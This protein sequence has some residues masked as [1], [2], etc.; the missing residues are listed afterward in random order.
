MFAHPRI[1]EI[2]TRVWLKQL[3]IRLNRQINLDNIPP[4]EWLK[5]RN[6]GCDWV[7]LMGVWQ[8]SLIS[9]Q[10]A[11]Q[12]SNLQIEYN[13]VLPDW[14]IEDIVGSPYAVKDYS[15]NYE[16]G[17]EDSL[18]YTKDILHHYGIKL[19]LDF[20]PNHT[21][22]DHHWVFEHPEYYIQQQEENSITNLNIGNKY[23]AYGKDPNYAPWQDT[24]Q[25]N[26]FNLEARNALILQLNKIASFCD[27]VRC[28]MAMLVTNDIFANTWKKELEEMEY[29]KPE[30]EFWCHAISQNKSNKPKFQF[31]A[32]CYWNTESMMQD[33]GFDFTYDKTLYDMLLDNNFQKINNFLNNQSNPYKWLRFIENHDEKRA[34]LEFG[35]DRSKAAAILTSFLPG[36]WLLHQNQES[37]YKIK[38][39]VQ[40]VTQPQDEDNTKLA[41]FYRKVGGI[42]NKIFSSNY[43]KL[44]VNIAGW[45][46]NSSYLNLICLAWQNNESTYIIVINYSDSQSQGKIFFTQKDGVDKLCF[47]D[48]VT[49]KEYS[50][51]SNKIKNEGL[52]VDLLPWQFHIFEIK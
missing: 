38:L 7:W 10:L 43:Q 18:N 28:D 20:V 46:D 5:I 52:F 36:A 40:L 27:G 4:Q 34:M 41:I 16:L 21:A 13:K 8:K 31:V 32:E 42:I 30:E 6:L 22:C 24:L 51:D 48:L 39:P 35:E 49:N 45:D 17:D 29:T 23:L 19:M 44:E 3:S 9:Q 15:L 12:D 37:G 47:F 11:R 14:C 33:Q 2:N 26:Y 1:Y 25:L 50:Y